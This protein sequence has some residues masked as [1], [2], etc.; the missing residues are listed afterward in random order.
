MRRSQIHITAGVF[1]IVLT[2]AACAPTGAVGQPSAS[3]VAT[4][5]A[6]LTMRWGQ[7]LTEAN[8]VYLKGNY[9]QKYGLTVR[10]ILFSTG[11]DSR[12]ALIGGQIDV[13]ELGITPAVTALART[14]DLL[15][16]ATSD[17]GGG[18]YRLMVK[19]GSTAKTFEDL[20]GKKIA[21]QVGSGAYSAFLGVAKSKGLTAKDFQILNIGDVDAIAALEQGSVDAVQYWEPIVSIIES[22]GIGRELMSYEGLVNNPVLIL[23][24]RQW[25]EQNRAAALAFAAGWSDALEFMTKQPN[26]AAKIIVN[27]LA[28]KGQKMDVA[29]EAKAL[30]HDHYEPD[31][32][33]AFITDLKQ[34]WANGVAQGSFKGTEPD[35]SAVYRPEIV[36]EAQKLRK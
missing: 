12:D 9:A 20:K 27:A 15:I 7:R 10:P 2:M 34:S 4:R 14:T 22:K 6:D 29:V 19:T 28:E 16:I 21:V 5:P 31:L 8:M 11:I 25:V 33:P 35:W 32:K 30:P 18:K 1:A 36:Q 24:R 3:A 13:A 17:W 23:A 26:E